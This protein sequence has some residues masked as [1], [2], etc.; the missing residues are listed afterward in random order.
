MP[1]EVEPAVSESAECTDVDMKVLE[2]T[3]AEQSDCDDLVA[4]TS[5]PLTAEKVSSRISNL[6]LS[7]NVPLP[8][9]SGNPNDFIEFD[10]D[11]DDGN[12]Q[13]VNEQ[14]V[15]QLMERLLQHSR[16]SGHPRKPKTV[17]IRYE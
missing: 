7:S 12:S 11:D 14:G 6:V 13:Q 17:E 2:D 1:V 9:L 4:K 10:D 5:Q 8:Q 15:E 3:T 16:G